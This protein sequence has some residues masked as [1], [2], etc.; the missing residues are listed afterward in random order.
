MGSAGEAGSGYDCTMEYKCTGACVCLHF[1]CMCAALLLQFLAAAQ[2]HS[3]GGGTGSACR[4]FPLKCLFFFPTGF[5]HARH[6]SETRGKHG[7][8]SDYICS[9][10]DLQ[11]KHWSPNEKYSYYPLLDISSHCLT[12]KLHS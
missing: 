3:L 6:I 2:R 10:G 11:S 12:T 1:T 4:Y 7:A 5:K 8:V 9:P